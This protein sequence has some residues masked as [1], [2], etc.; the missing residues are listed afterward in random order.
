MFF[1][2]FIDNLKFTM[3]FICSNNLNIQRLWFCIV[4]FI[5]KVLKIQVFNVFVCIVNKLKNNFC[6]KTY[7]FLNLLF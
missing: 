5:K 2:S 3:C 6:V 4:V 7:C 1:F